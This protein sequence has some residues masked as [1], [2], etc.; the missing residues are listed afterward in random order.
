MNSHIARG[1]SQL[2][3]VARNRGYSKFLYQIYLK[4]SWQWKTLSF[5]METMGKANCF[6]H[7]NLVSVAP[8]LLGLTSS[9]SPSAGWV[10][11]LPSVS[12]RMVCWCLW[13]G[14]PC[15][16]G[17]YRMPNKMSP[18][19]QR[20]WLLLVVWVWTTDAR[21][22]ATP[23]LSDARLLIRWVSTGITSYP[24][25]SQNQLLVVSYE[26]DPII[27]FGSLI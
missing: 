17:Q 15:R 4:S 8:L 22:L 2:S 10:P 20:G 5:G 26:V 1:W 9:F 6:V 18:R 7:R 21:L 23:N 11:R 27:V 24:I 3:V 16:L 19:K 25:S 12:L 14:R 13:L